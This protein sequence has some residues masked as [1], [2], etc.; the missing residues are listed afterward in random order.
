MATSDKLLVKQD[1]F[2]DINLPYS[3]KR[4]EVFPLNISVFNYIDSQ[5]PVRLELTADEDS[6]ETDTKTV[7]ICVKPNNNKVVTLKVAALQLGEVN[8]TVK[9]TITNGIEGCS[10]VASGNGFYD[11]LVKPLRVKAEGVPVEIVQSDF[12]CITDKDDEEFKLDN[13]DLPDDIVNGSARGWVSVTGDVMAPALKNIG[14]LVRMPTGCGEQNMV[15]LVPNIY[16]LDYLRGTNK[17]MVDIEQKAINYMNIGYKRQ[18]NYR[19]SDGS[20][21]IW[22]GKGDKD[23]STW[24]TAFVV[25]AFSEA[26]KYISID[27]ELVQQSVNWLLKGQMENGCFMKRGYVHSSYLKG[28]AS[29]DSLTAFVFTAL[30]AANTAA[31]LR[32]EIDQKKLDRAHDCMLENVNTTDLYSTIVVAH[33]A[34]LVE[35]YER[36]EKV[37]EL[38]ELI[39]DKANTTGGKFWEVKKEVPECKYCWWSYRPSSEAV[40]MTAYNVMTYVIRDELPLALDS[41]KWLARQRNSQGEESSVTLKSFLVS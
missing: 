38:M 3:V 41:V 2:A 33:A 16:L 39:N 29:D 20:Y 11:A 27:S 5:L 23:G 18:N 28:G 25:K 30:Q 37:V 9:A 6:L 32:L 12:K 21:S 1:F 4:K 31:E 40:E 15:G 36:N 22:G 26:S 14:H 19:H 35:D 10:E 24:L 13:L 34:H 17:E 8:V 7:E